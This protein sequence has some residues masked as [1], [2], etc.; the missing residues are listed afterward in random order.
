MSCA[1]VQAGGIGP[2]ME[3]R[4]SIAETKEKLH[5]G[6]LVNKGLRSC[7]YHEWIDPEAM[8]QS[9]ESILIEER[10]EGGLQ[11]EWRHIL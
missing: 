6:L 1:W 7:L 4:I 10:V 9:L 2:E 11:R 3:V 8:G 5:A